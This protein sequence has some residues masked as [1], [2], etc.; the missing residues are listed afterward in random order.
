VR[1]TATLLIAL[2][3]VSAVAASAADWYARGGYYDSGWS[4]DA[5]NLL[6]DPN[7]DGIYTGAVTSPMAAGYYEGKVALSDWS[8]SY[9]NSNQP[10][11]ISGPGDVVHWTFDT[12]TYSDGW[13]PSTN[14][15]MSDH[16]IP[17]DM[18]FEVM[19]SFN[20]W[21]G[22]VTATLTDYVWSAETMVATAGNYE[23]KFRQTGNWGINV[24]SDGYGTNSNNAGFT[25]TQDNQAVLFQFNQVTGRMRIVVGGWVVPTTNQ[26]WG[27]LKSL[28]R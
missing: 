11:F 14:I 28:Y 8:V 10:V 7:A 24:G 4:A 27:A 1:K 21:S 19:G 26:T 2:M 9:P 17:A 22:P 5:G 20:G 18:T 12:N 25:T 3:L 13:L 15:V 6:T 23:A 16:A